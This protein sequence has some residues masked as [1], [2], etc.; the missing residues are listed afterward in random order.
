MPSRPLRHIRTFTGRRRPRFR[1]EGRDLPRLQIVVGSEPMPLQPD[2]NR[3]GY[4]TIRGHPDAPAAQAVDVDQPTMS[5]IA[6]AE[7]MALSWFPSWSFDCKVCIT[8]NYECHGESVGPSRA[9]PPPEE[10]GHPWRGGAPGARTRLRQGSPLTK[11]AS[12]P[13]YRRAH[14]STASQ[15]KSPRSPTAPRTYPLS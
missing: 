3:T 14:S 1:F 13:E 12:K 9:P 11:S 8:C 6:A 2:R 15:T 7:V 5:K 10:R 4:Q